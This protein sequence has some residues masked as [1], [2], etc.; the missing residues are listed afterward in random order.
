MMMSTS[1]IQEKREGTS[2]KK[3]RQVEETSCSTGR[4]RYVRWKIRQVKKELHKLGSVKDRFSK[5]LVQY[6][7]GTV[8]DEYSWAHV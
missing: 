1:G 3:K 5:R 8:K 2:M 7:V 6:K 4:D